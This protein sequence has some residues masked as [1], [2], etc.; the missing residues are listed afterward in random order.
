MPYGNVMYLSSREG[1]RLPKAKYEL[2]RHM[3][4]LLNVTQRMRTIARWR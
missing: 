2:A 4:E 3:S 1:R